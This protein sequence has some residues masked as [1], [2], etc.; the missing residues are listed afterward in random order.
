MF[1]ARAPFYVN[2]V[3]VNVFDIKLSYSQPKEQLTLLK[4]KF[5]VTL[6]VSS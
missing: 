1:I 4:A 3:D 6:N 2:Y 5:G